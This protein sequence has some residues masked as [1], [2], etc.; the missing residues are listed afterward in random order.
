M[1]PSEWFGYISA[2]DQ[3]HIP[4]DEPDGLAQ[5][6]FASSKQMIFNTLMNVSGYGQTLCRYFVDNPARLLL[7][8]V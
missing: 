2:L 8:F 4:G 3:Q 1:Y 6:I 7:M 5:D